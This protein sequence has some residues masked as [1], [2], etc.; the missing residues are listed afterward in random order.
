VEE[1]EDPALLFGDTEQPGIYTLLTPDQKGTLGLFAVNLEGYESDLTYL[2]DVLAPDV[3]GALKKLMKRDLVA[4]VD[5][6]EQVT[7]VAAGIRSGTKLWDW[8]LLLVLGIALFEPW[9]A[10]RISLRHYGKSRHVPVLAGPEGPQSSRP[11]A[12]RPVEEVRS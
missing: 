10:N 12:D 7:E 1:A 6:P 8:I 9:L 4:F 5:D 11:L 3:E 2:D